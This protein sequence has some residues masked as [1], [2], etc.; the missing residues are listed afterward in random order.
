MT[1]QVSQVEALQVSQ[2]EALRPFRAC[3]S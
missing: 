2:V 1:L 3:R